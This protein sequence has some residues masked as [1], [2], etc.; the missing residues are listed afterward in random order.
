MYFYIH[1]K[2]KNEQTQLLEMCSNACFRF[3]NGFSV[4]L[5]YSNQIFI[6]KGCGWKYLQPFFLFSKLR[7]W[8]R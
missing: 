1:K 5:A 4:Y 8:K 3:R 7:K 2:D 6:V